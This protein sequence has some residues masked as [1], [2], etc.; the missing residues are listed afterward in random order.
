MLITLNPHPPA[1]ASVERDFLRMSTYTNVGGDGKL[2]SPAENNPAK[3]Q[4]NKSSN[5]P[6]NMSPKDPRI[7]PMRYHTGAKRHS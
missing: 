3:N 7:Q 6:H 1:A 2:S 5:S 4:K